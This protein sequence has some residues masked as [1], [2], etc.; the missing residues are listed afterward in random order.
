MYAFRLTPIRTVYCVH[1]YAM[2]QPAQPVWLEI[3]CGK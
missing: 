1:D 3:C 2:Y